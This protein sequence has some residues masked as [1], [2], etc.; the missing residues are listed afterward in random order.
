MASI[1]LVLLFGI[2]LALTK[3]RVKIG[4]AIAIGSVIAGFMFSMDP[5]QI[6][7]SIY[8]GAISL[9]TFQLLVILVSVS[10]L[11]SLL[12]E[13]GLAS[14]LTGAVESLLRSKR[15][16]MAILPAMIGLLPM[17]GGALLSAP[18]VDQAGVHTGVAPKRL[19]AINYWFRHVWEYIWPLYPG[20]ILSASILDVKA[21]T[22]VSAQWPMSVGM[23]VGGIL[24][25][26][27]PL[28]KL[29]T[30]KNDVRS[31]RNLASV[32]ASLWPIFLAVSLSLVFEIRLYIAVTASLLAFILIRRFPKRL[33]LIGL[34]RAVTFEYVSFVFAVMIFKT[35]LID[36]GAAVQVAAEITTAGIDPIWV[37]MFIPFIIGLISGAT[38]AFVSLAYPALLP[39]IKPDGIDVHMLAVAYTAG[40]LGTLLSPLHFCLVLTAEYFKESLTPVYL[41]IIGPLVVMVA[42]LLLLIMLT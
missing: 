38:P 33:L 28:G 8:A 32:F 1:K 27:L 31:G 29:E 5:L 19:A 21:A 34:K 37:V 22:I 15:A 4:L 30:H 16:S 13:S 17:P 24:F 20:I 9:D 40:F 2:I 42:G 25:L 23:I 3:V 11:G 7:S 14:N 36:S 18:L 6:G 26:L 35:V 10:F 41:Y 12:K 39:F